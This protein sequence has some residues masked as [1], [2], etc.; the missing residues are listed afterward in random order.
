MKY[1]KPVLAL[2]LLA[3][4][5]IIAFF[6]FRV[7]QPISRTFRSVAGDGLGTSHQ[8]QSENPWQAWVEKQTDET[9]K[10]MVAANKKHRQIKYPPEASEI[11]KWRTDIHTHMTKHADMMKEKYPSPTAMEANGDGL[12]TEVTVTVE[13]VPSER[14]TG[15]QTV[16]ALMAAFDETYDRPNLTKVDEKYPRAEWLAML[17]DKGVILG[18]YGDYS[19]FMNERWN[20]VHFEEDGHW[21]WGVEGVPQTDDWE[22]FK[23]AYI[24]R[25]AWE[26]QQIYAE[27]QSDPDVFGGLFAGPDKRTYLPGRG[28]RV[29]VQREGRSAFFH[30][31]PLAPKQ[32]WDIMLQGKHPEGYEIIYID[33][34]GTILSEPPPPIPPPAGEERRQ[35]EAWLKRGENQQTSDMPDQTSEDWDDWDS[36]GQD[37]PSG[38]ETM[39]AEAQDVQKQF[40][41]AQTEA[42]ERATKGDTEIG[43]ELEKQLT[44]ELLT[45]EGVETELSGRFS[46]ERLEK[47]RE[48]LGRYGPE[49]GMRRL[50]EDDP[51]VAAQVE[52]QRRNR[53][54]AESETEEPENPTR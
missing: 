35:L 37:R 33:E 23:A 38:D 20:L 45:T 27:R 29:Y 9:T 21:R 19:L 25:K 7:N 40:E 49:E 18:D 6:V 4:I 8:K 34:N 10:N 54:P 5:G 46:P 26:F 14:Y 48:V 53:N 12:S 43:A 17:L 44:P 3:T 39:S 30:G 24:D 11:A 15:P 51:E 22:T 13:D 42:L 41:R 47:A 16:G 36:G 50:R 1:Q 2:S 52:R 32:Q 31:A 28:N